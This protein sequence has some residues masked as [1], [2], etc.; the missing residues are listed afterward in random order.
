[1]V[2]KNS[3]PCA[4]KSWRG[5]VVEAFDDLDWLEHFAGLPYGAQ[6]SAEELKNRAKRH[7]D[8][9]AAI[10]S[11]E[12]ILYSSLELLEQ[13]LVSLSELAASYHK[14]MNA[15][16][17]LA[18]RS[19]QRQRKTKH[20]QRRLRD[21]KKDREKTKD[22]S[23]NIAQAL[24]SLQKQRSRIQTFHSDFQPSASAS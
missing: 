13:D 7:L 14:V 12:V 3:G 1:M 11:D 5:S 4:E 10:A 19:F 17:K 21:L 22:R 6:A 23:E 20:R 15:F 18:E 8:T 24:R 2:C 16:F 9:V